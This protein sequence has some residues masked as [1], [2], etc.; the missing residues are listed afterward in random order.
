MARQHLTDV[1]I[2]QLPHPTTG[3]VKY[4]DTVQLGFGVRVGTRRKS[5]FVMYGQRRQLHTLGTYGEISLSAARKEA[6]RYLDR[7]DHNKRPERFSEALSAYLEDCEA[8]LRPATLTMYRYYLSQV[9]RTY[10]TDITPRDIDRTHPQTVATW[11]AFYNWCI[12]QGYI[13]RNPFTGLTSKTSTRDRVLTHDEI[14]AVWHVADPLQPYLRALLLTGVRRGE[15]NGMQVGEMLTI[16]ETKNG[17]P[18][19]LPLSPLVQSLVPLP[20]FNG[21]SKAKARIDAKLQLPHWTLHDLRRTFATEHAKLGTPIHVVE[22]LLNHRSGT[23][24]GV[25]RIY[26]RY[27]FIAEAKKA[28]IAYEQHLLSFLM[29]WTT[30]D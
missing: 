20:Y 24:S 21:W 15:L 1:A 18:H 27:S 11:K 22:A 30:P 12:R 17:Q 7:P 19:H 4:W 2:R 8:R 28:Q 13:D 23:I 10:L 16:P 5:F 26:V 29:P 3:T 25:A 14:R 9:Q 6:R